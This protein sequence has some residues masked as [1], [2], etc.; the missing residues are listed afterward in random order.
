[1]P[2]GLAYMKDVQPRER[3]VIGLDPSRS[4]V[5]EACAGSGKTWLLVSR[6]LRL[7]LV[8]VKPG[9]IL[10]ITYTRKAAREIEERL[11]QYLGEL[12]TAS[13]DEAINFLAQR[14]LTMAQATAA[15]PRAR[16]LLEEV[17]QADPPI[18]ITTFHG[19]F[20]RLL[21]GAPL[22]S[23]LTGFALDENTRLFLDEAW[24]ELSAACGRDTDGE[25]SRALLWLFQELGA[26]N[27]RKLLHC[28]IE[29]RAEWQAWCTACGGIESAIQASE[30]AFGIIAANSPYEQFFNLRRGDLRVYAEALKTNGKKGAELH[31]AITQALLIENTEDAFLFV[32]EVFLTSKDEP[33]IFKLVKD[34]LAKLGEHESARIERLH[35]ELCEA[36]QDALNV[37]DDLHNAELNRYALIAGNALLAAFQRIKRTR[38][39]MDFT[40]LEC[41]VDKLLSDE[42]H[43][44]F[45]QARL[46]AR[47]RQILLDEFQD[48]NPM[49]WRTLRAWLDAYGMNEQRPSVFLVGDPKQSIYRF[50]RAEPKLFAAAGE[51]FEQHFGAHLLRDDNTYRNALPVVEIIN[52][53]FSTEPQF[54]DFREQSASKADWPG[55]VEVLQLVMRESVDEEEALSSSVRD[56][57]QEAID[58]M[59]D[60]RRTQEAKQVVQHIRAMV[61]SMLIRNKDGSERPAR[62]GDILILT[63]KKSVLAELEIA[64]REAAIPF[65]GPGRG[66]LLATLEARDIIALMRF[67]A[68]PAD[69]LAL[70]HVLRTPAFDVNDDVL[71]RIAAQGES[72]WWQSLQ[73]LAEEENDNGLTAIVRLLDDWLVASQHLPAHDLLDRVF[74]SADWRNRYRTRVP[75]AM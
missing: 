50:R 31:V 11:R 9:E 37:L 20:A 23:G 15:L 28:F 71:L 65:M 17:L 66:G 58:S 59:E 24:A 51:Y 75:A 64:L 72:N 47:Y 39:V 19:W 46:D 40:D 70:A 18:T 5:V 54:A 49:Q 36:V 52:R 48:T 44:A 33:R 1:M 55:R 61:G 26:F 3:V 35:S 27:T 73:R 53:L 16:G 7:L 32:R 21:S 74:H 6:L 29:R 10:A 45:I 63:R 68:D 30:D 4:V 2:Q 56:P 62:Y 60:A 8:G 43:A 13:H 41:E 25:V 67:L 57:L 34:V 38:R 22:E 42:Q 12:A 14:G 69:N